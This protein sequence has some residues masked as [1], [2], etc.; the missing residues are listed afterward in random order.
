MPT[1]TSM[2]K[3][4]ATLSRDYAAVNEVLLDSQD[5]VC[6]EDALGML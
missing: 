1:Y 5:G 2:H 4:K 6:I 3:L